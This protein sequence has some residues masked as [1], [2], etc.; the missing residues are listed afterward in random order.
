MGDMEK[1]ENEKKRKKRRNP[2]DRG[3]VSRCVYWSVTREPFAHFFSFLF[4]TLT[5]FELVKLELFS[6]SGCGLG[7]QY[8]SRFDSRCLTPIPPY[9]RGMGGTFQPISDITLL[10]LVERLSW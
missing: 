4:V 2:P 8:C 7:S 10:V 9:P 6:D 5:T 1:N 3:Q